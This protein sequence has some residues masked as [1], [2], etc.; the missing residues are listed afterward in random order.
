MFGQTGLVQDVLG[1]VLDLLYMQVD[2]TQGTLAWRFLLRRRLRKVCFLA[3]G[4][5]W[6]QA[7]VCKEDALEFADVIREI[8]GREGLTQEQ[9]AQKIGVTRQAVSKWETGKNLPDIQIIIGMATLFNVSLDELI[10]GRSPKEEHMSTHASA[11]HTTP[12]AEKLIQDGLETRRA[13]LNL[14][15]CIVALIAC[16]LGGLMLFIYAHSV[17]YVDADGMV[18]ESFYLVGLGSFLLAL[19]GIILLVA[20][21]SY[22]VHVLRQRH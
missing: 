10:L 3:S 12:V 7:C 21:I 16:G 5:S 9:F 6:H 13:K 8:R 11:E 4:K 17:S 1:H 18:H 19:G 20:L 2:A 15:A 22:L 14:S